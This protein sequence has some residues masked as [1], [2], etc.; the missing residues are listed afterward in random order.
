MSQGMFDHVPVRA[1]ILLFLGLIALA[2]L[3]YVLKYMAHGPDWRGEVPHWRKRDHL[4][5]SLIVI[6]SL[7]AFALFIFTP[8]A[9]A[10]VRADSFWPAMTLAFGLLVI[11]TVYRGAVTGQIE[12]LVRG[13]RTYART[14]EPK[15]YWASITWNAIMGLGL[16]YGGVAMFTDRSQNQCFHVTGAHDAPGALDACNALLEKVHD[17]GER[18]HIFGARGQA[19]YWLNEQDR[20]IADY[21]RAIAMDPQDS[22]AIYNRALAYAVAGKPAKALSDYDRSLAL[23]P[24]NPEGHLAR[25]EI[26]TGFGQLDKAITDF[27]KAHEANPKTPEPIADR[28]V[29]YALKGD[30]EAAYSDL[31]ALKAIDP[32][33][34]ALARIPAIF[35][36]K[37]KDWH[38]AITELSYALAKDP[39][40]P[41][42]LQMRANAYWAIGERDKARADDD[43][44]ENIKRDVHR[45]KPGD[46]R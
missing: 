11:F 17:K 32:S 16:L 23:R 33:N 13:A 30:R 18:Q 41:W 3:G 8:Q 9:E 37:A 27:T 21:T 19:Y 2:P 10:I 31:K 6:A 38:S 4:M 14:V 1:W 44:F 15:R 24:D 12:P 45:A 40:D 28:A 26:L 43:L 22:F 25:G 35:A 42:A 34:R 29:A 7:A 5:R 39:K 36:L 20:A 46:G